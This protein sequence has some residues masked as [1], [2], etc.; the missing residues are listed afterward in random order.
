MLMS[1]ALGSYS[2]HS[3]SE[4][5]FQDQAVQLALQAEATENMSDQLLQELA[6][7]APQAVE[8]SIIE[9]ADLTPTFNEIKKLVDKKNKEIEKLSKQAKVNEAQIAKIGLELADAQAALKKAE[10]LQRAKH[11]KSHKLEQVINDALK[12]AEQGLKKLNDSVAFQ[13][14]KKA[15]VDTSEFLSE[16]ADKAY[17]NVSETINKAS[18][19]KSKAS[20]AVIKASAQQP[21]LMDEDVM[22]DQAMDDAMLDE[23]VVL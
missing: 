10:A 23:E 18:R 16:K 9:T 13:T 2:L 3:Q 22:I 15:S 14:I 17:K 6:Q 8:E 20:K 21:M 7:I 5:E 4:Q 1:L 19:K 12:K 11:K